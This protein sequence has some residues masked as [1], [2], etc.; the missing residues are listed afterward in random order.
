M[1]VLLATTTFG[2][3]PTSGDLTLLPARFSRGEG[4]ERFERR[5]S[6]VEQLWRFEREPQGEGDLVVA[7][8][9]RGG[10]SVVPRAGGLDFRQSAQG[11]FLHYGAATWVEADGRT[12]PVALAW[13]G[14]EILLTVPAAVLGRTRWPAVLDPLLTTEQPIQPV[15]LD[16]ASSAQTLPAIAEGGATCL[17]VWEDYRQGEGDIFG[18]RV[19]CATGTTLDPASL[20]VNVAPGNQVRPAVSWN[21]QD[22]WVVWRDDAAAP[23]QLVGT[24]VASDGTRLDPNGITFGNAWYAASPAIATQGGTALAV[25][26]GGPG[27]IPSILGQRVDASG[28]TVGATFTVSVTAANEVTPR[29]TANGTGFFAVWDS[30]RNGSHDIYGARVDASGGVLDPGGLP[31]AT[32]ASDEV[33]PVVAFDGT[34]YLVAWHTGGVGIQAT[35]VS[36]NGTPLDSPALTLS[37]QPDVAM[38]P[39]TTFDGTQFW[40]I[41]PINTGGVRGCRVAADG[42]VLDATPFVVGSAA[43][44]GTGTL[45]A[46]DAGVLTV[47]GDHKNVF[48]TESLV[49]LLFEPSGTPI[50]APYTLTLGGTG[51]LNAVVAPTATGFVVTWNEGSVGDIYGKGLPVD[52]VPDGGAGV[53][54][55]GS[56]NNGLH[57]PAIAS[58]G[59]GCLVAYTDASNGAIIRALTL[60]STGN[61]TGPELAVSPLGSRDDARVAFGGG[62]YLVVWDYGGPPWSVEAARVLPDGGVLDASPLVLGSP[63]IDHEPWPDVTFDGVDFQVVWEDAASGHRQ[64]HGTRVTVGGG[65]S[66]P[67]VLLTSSAHEHLNPRI[68]SGAGHTLVAWADM[69]GPETDVYGVE[70]LPN[71]TPGP[72]L[73]LVVAPGT[74]DT[75]AVAFTGKH[76]ALAWE[77]GRNPNVDIDVYGTLLDPATLA[78][79][80]GGWPL[81]A[82]A[83]RDMEPA[84]AAGPDGRLL[85]A[86]SH[87]DPTPSLHAL[88][89]WTELWLDDADGGAGDGGAGGGGAGGG[90]GAAN[91]GGGGPRPRVLDVRCGCSTSDSAGVVLFALAA[92]GRAVRRRRG[93]C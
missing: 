42:T 26:E 29:L 41:W 73:P 11:L 72:E 37:P 10:W 47:L 65:V 5:G 34:Q 84:L 30:A 67:G 8:P 76:F 46:T 43:G 16:E 44:T 60:D 39:S 77:D 38:Y 86:W 66:S 24:R 31:I 69:L 7:V 12:T 28:A 82:S 59:I 51:E 49:A 78:T 15:L 17:V 48:G 70:W 91:A 75:L 36:A 32:T 79:T 27:L 87:F 58:E 50:G 68:V 40:V 54:L 53:L 13:N 83:Y 20:L 61:A 45:S 23:T 6:G 81:G 71:D 64:L 62:L 1:G 63:Q 33:Q 56:G 57:A 88:R 4:V 22:F 14:A 52:G 55:R 35:R 19:I 74:Q 90:G 9:V 3:H 2:P 92:A 89:V 93:A 25:W 80:D 85:V 18:Q 21:G